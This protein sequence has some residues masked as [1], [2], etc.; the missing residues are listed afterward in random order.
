MPRWTGCV[1]CWSVADIPQRW[2]IVGSGAIARRH[3]DC[4]IARSNTVVLSRL[5]SSGKPP[6]DPDIDTHMSAV[7]FSWDEAIRW[8]PEAAV[9]ANAA[10]KHAYAV[11]RLVDAR[12][13]VLVEKPLS[14]SEADA[15]LLASHVGDIGVPVL[16]GYCLR[17]HS[18]V[19]YVLKTVAS[20]R[21]GDVVQCTAH[22]GQ[23]IDDWRLLPSSDS[24][25]LS[26]ELG[27]GALLELSHEIDLA[28]QLVGP[29]ARVLAT[30]GHA[31]G[32][33]V[34]AA[35][36]LLLSTGDSSVSVTLNMLE[37]P[38]RRTLTVVGSKGSLAADLLTGVVVEQ[39]GRG[40][41]VCREFPDRGQMYVR[42]LDHFIRCIDG[43]DAPIVSVADAVEVLAC[44]ERARDSHDARV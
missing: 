34:E 35:A 4:I 15:T 12:V 29:P 25:S 18:T 43:I 19:R 6:A 33:R 37:R 38:A 9:V 17:H 32:W 1:R 22:V 5:S 42:Q 30:L 21:L 7:H 13:P 20:G 39:C 40:D 2:L 8:G 11:R 27:G 23:H 41:P 28:L 24:V 3:V 10:S 44:I 31:E 16:V 14:A 26:P 36:S